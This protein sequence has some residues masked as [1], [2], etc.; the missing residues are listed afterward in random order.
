MATRIWQVAKMTSTKLEPFS[1]GDFSE[2]LERLEF[3]TLRR[4]TLEWFR[5]KPPGHRLPPRQR[6]RLPTSFSDCLQAPEKNYAAGLIRAYVCEVLRVVNSCT[7]FLPLSDWH[8]HQSSQL[9]SFSLFIASLLFS[10]W[11]LY[12][13]FF[14]PLKKY[15]VPW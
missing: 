6:K 3:Y 11:R 13:F 5:P 10:S 7:H 15:F 1:G 4:M 8:R 2:Y 9:D 14:S 12:L